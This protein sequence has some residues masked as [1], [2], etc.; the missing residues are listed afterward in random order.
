[1]TADLRAELAAN[2]DQAEWSWL[3]PHVERDV[4]VVVTPALDLLDV[5]VAIASDHVLLV[6]RWIS[7]GLI[8]KP[9]PA[10]VSNWNQNP[11]I[12]FLALIVQPYVL[13]QPGMD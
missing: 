8:Q 13:V 10:Q 9:D 11:N 7:E 3:L 6:Q 2:L 5:G 1:M 12:S 4:V